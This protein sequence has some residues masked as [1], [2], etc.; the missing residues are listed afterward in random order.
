MKIDFSFARAERWIHFEHPKW[1]LLHFSLL[2]AHIFVSVIREGVLVGEILMT[3][4][5][6]I[7]SFVVVV[8]KVVRKSVM[9]LYDEGFELFFGV[10]ADTV[11]S[12]L[13]QRVPMHCFACNSDT[14]NDTHSPVYNKV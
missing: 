6:P 13:H 5:T 12:P 9:R 2:V 3:V 10:Q 1:A 14:F 7:P 11:G 8:V 4:S